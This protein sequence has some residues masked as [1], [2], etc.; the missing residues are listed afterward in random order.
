MG[1]SSENK[2]YNSDSNDMTPSKSDETKK[3][4]FCFFTSIDEESRNKILEENENKRISNNFFLSDLSVE[5]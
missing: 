1:D 4:E 5:D 2:I 3:S